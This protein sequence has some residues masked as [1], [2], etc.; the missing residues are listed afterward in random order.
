M[1]ESGRIQKFV[2]TKEET[3]MTFEEQFPSLKGKLCEDSMDDT[4]YSGVGEDVATHIKIDD[5]REH[6][7]D[8]KKVLDAIDKELIYM[9]NQKIN[10]TNQEF[11][12]RIVDVER[13]RIKQELGLK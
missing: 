11:F 3:K 9:L 1:F 6:C 12:N 4:C 10:E 7:L 8:R 5:V 2:P 13:K